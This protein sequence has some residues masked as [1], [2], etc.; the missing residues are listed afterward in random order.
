LHNPEI[1][2]LD[3]PTIGLDVIAKRDLR[4]VL[5]H[6]NN[7]WKTTIFLTSH[8][9]GDIEA[10]CKRTVVV[11]HGKI[12]Y[13][14]KTKNLRRKYVTIK[15]LY[16]RFEEKVDDFSMENVK[17]LN[18]SDLEVSLEVNTSQRSIKSVL[19]ELIKK[20]SIVDINV[21]DPSLEEIIR[22]IYEQQDS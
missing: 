4:D 2:F 3:E 16:V 10:L 20:Y 6:L 9:T 21:E 13:D 1:I 11:N 12:I 8:D 14:D 18:K 17:T 19:E 7:V 5:R 15:R 22:N